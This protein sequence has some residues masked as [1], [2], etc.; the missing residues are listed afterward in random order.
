LEGITRYDRIRQFNLDGKS[1]LVKCDTVH[2][3]TSYGRD[4]KPDAGGIVAD[5]FT[6]DNMQTA[7]I[8]EIDRA[9]LDRSDLTK[10]QRQLQDGERDAIAKRLLANEGELLQLC[11][12]ERKIGSD[13]KSGGYYL[14]DEEMPRTGGSVLV[15][16]VA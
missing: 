7:K 12:V 5:V 2:K 9:R 8:F 10:G 11:E 1:Y 14:G 13:W 6:A 3:S 4:G 15:S 16:A